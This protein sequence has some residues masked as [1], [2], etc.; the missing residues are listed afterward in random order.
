MRMILESGKPATY[1][2]D[3]DAS[4]QTLRESE[5][6]NVPTICTKAGEDVAKRHYDLSKKEV[7]CGGNENLKQLEGGGEAPTS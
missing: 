5:S 7:N 6:P 3:T 1:P 4:H 2:T